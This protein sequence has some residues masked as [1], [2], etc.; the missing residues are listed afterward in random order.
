[1]SVLVSDASALL[2]YLLGTEAG[3]GVRA[4]VRRADVDLHVPAL[5][6]VEV[7]AGLRRAVIRGGLSPQRA[8]EALK[9]YVDMPV[10]RHGHQQLLR[11]ALE[12]RA[13]FTAYDAVY[14]VLAERTAG[15]LMT[16]DAGL[17]KAA[18]AHTRIEILP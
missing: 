3:E 10:T 5:C 18:K 8:E 12:L 9:D 2:E 6:D 15:A 17:A 14:V 16:L 11:R 7:V 1:V 13:N 4:V